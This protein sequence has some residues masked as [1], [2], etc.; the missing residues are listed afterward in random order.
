MQILHF[1]SSIVIHKLYHF[2]KLNLQI[3]DQS[4]Y[5]LVKKNQ[6]TI[7]YSN[8]DIKKPVVH[9]KST[10]KGYDEL[11]NCYKSGRGG[12]IHKHSMQILLFSL[13]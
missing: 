1:F 12:G 10:S 5:Q 4:C 6:Q 8:E 2:A 13:N 9:V 3:S 7:E 11:L